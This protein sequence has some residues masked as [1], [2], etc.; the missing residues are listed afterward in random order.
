MII[1][2][3]ICVIVIPVVRSTKSAIGVFYYQVG[4][5]LLQVVGNHDTSYTA[6]II[7]MM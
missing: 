4:I 1:T 3:Q 7:I 2:E 5:Y 6:T